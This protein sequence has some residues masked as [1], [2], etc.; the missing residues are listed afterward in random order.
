MKFDEKEIKALREIVAKEMKRCRVDASDGLFA[1]EN[2]LR[3]LLEQIGKVGLADFLE[4]EKENEA[5]DH[6]EE[7]P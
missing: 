4:K 5:S 6:E 2:K 1:V 7:S 3:E